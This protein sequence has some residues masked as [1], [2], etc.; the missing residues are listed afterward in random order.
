MAFFELTGGP[1]LV[2]TVVLTVLVL[3]VS[4]LVLPRYR[5]PGLLKYVIQFLAIVLVTVL[6]L[7][8]VFFKLNN[9]NQWYSNWG[10]LFTGGS[11]GAVTSR[12]VGYSPPRSSAPR[13][14][15]HAPFSPVQRDPQS[16]PDIG[17][18]LDPSAQSGQWA[19]FTLPGKDSGVSQ[20]VAVWLPPS[21]FAHP[22]SAYPVITAFTGFP[23]SIKTYVDSMSFGQHIRVS[24]RNNQVRE[25]I[26]VIPDVY[27][28][29]TDTECVNSTKGRYE[30]FVTHDVVTWVR[31]NLRT[32]TEPGAWATLGYSA[33]GWCSSMFTVRHP[34]I[35]R[36]SV[37]LAGYFAPEYSPGQQWKTADPGGYDLARVVSRDKPKIDIWFFAGGEDT[38]ALNAINTFK[39][40]VTAPTGLVINTSQTGA[41]RVAL[42][43]G[44][45]EPALK[46]LG[47][48]SPYFAASGS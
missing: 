39:G 22:D 42:W 44:Q 16:V 6:T 14:L 32:S 37:N 45:L 43:E 9:D 47:E 7:L 40:A 18:Q 25:P 5:R 28:G 36:S 21:Y 48:T 12:A 10:D 38:A 33:G 8:T 15:P 11:G 35:W 20:Q 13:D 2:T 34:D 26:V 17:S 1:L 19:R 3:A 31:S 46:W 23:G 29:N 30:D 24:A 41:H 4:V 27:P